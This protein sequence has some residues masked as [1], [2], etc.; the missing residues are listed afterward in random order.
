M[1]YSQQNLWLIDERL[2]YH[3]FIASDKRLDA[4]PD[5][6]QSDSTKRADLL[7]FDRKIVFADG[8]QPI[9][10]IVTVE[11]KRPQRDDY[12][13]D[14]NPLTQSFDL[15]ADI[16]SGNF[17]DHRGRPISVA[18]NTIPGICYVICDLTPTLKRALKYLQA[19]ITPDGQGYYGYHRDYRA[20]YEVI[21][22]NKLLRDSQKRNRIFFEKLNVLGNM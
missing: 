8:E 3:S 20:Y 16:R 9:N 21:D 7:I 10:S 2:T 4:L 1:L 12:T 5:E 6:I 13:T 17:R 15:L 14:D 19:E 11:F 22:Y 18:T